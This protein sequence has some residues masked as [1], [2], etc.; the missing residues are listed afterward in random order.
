MYEKSMFPWIFNV[1]LI[2]LNQHSI[3][4]LH[5]IQMETKLLFPALKTPNSNFNLKGNFIISSFQLFEM[6][7]Q[8]KMKFKI[9][10]FE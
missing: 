7:Q 9:H 3:Y 5:R 8:G 10:D 6:N 1:D 2:H 4:L